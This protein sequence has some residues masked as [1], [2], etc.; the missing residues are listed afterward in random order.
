MLCQ[1]VAERGIFY[2]LHVKLLTIQVDCKSRRRIQYIHDESDGLLQHLQRD[3]GHVPGAWRAVRNCSS[4]L[5]LPYMTV[6]STWNFTVPTSNAMRQRIKWNALFRESSDNKLWWQGKLV[7]VV[8]NKWLH[9]RIIRRIYVASCKKCRSTYTAG[10][11]GIHRPTHLHMLLART[12]DRRSHH[13]MLHLICGSAN[14][15]FEFR[16]AMSKQLSELSI[17]ER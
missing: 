6:G 4:A 13:S 15:F 16:L 9:K 3:V 8:I 14:A 17:I 1:L 7:H 2:Q 12:D 10:D 11:T 5:L